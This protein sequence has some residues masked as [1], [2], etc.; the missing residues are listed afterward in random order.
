[1]NVSHLNDARFVIKEELVQ[2]SITVGERNFCVVYI[3]LCMMFQMFRH[4]ALE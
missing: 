3:F 4:D 2:I 1:M